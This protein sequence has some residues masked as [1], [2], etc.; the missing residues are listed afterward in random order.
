MNSKPTIGILL[1]DSSG[2][3]PEQVA[4]ALA[5]GF[6]QEICKPV[7]IG[8]VRILKNALKLIN[9][10][11]KYSEIEKSVQIIDQ[12]NQEPEKV[13]IGKIT[14]YCGK[15][16]SDMMK[17]ACELCKSGEIKGFVYAPLNKAAMKDGGMKFEDEQH[18]MADIF[19]IKDTFG[20]INALGNL[21]T[22]RVTSH[23]PLSQVSEN[24]TIE[25]VLRAIELSY[26]TVKST[27]IDNPCVSVAALNPHAGENGLCGREEIDVLAPAIELA[28]KR[29][30][31]VTGPYPADTL[32]IR[33]F[34]GDFDSVVTMFHDQGQ[35][36]IKVKGFENGVT[37]SGGLPYPIAT[38]AH[39]T[40]YDIVNKGIAS[41]VP[42]E[43]AVKI[44]VKMAS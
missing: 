38:P 44:V 17:F 8:D 24:L 43:C 37:I 19:E 9:A 2:I 23:I 30:M 14:A 25:R 13:E 12:K 40:A 41:V 33:A 1:G 4:K 7:I 6:L 29:G 21:M 26:K 20:E 22:S 35:I 15:A 32:F 28:Q 39:G 16:A 5:S 11:A 3:G 27:G 34:N 18:F 10:E 42:F 36:A 31:N